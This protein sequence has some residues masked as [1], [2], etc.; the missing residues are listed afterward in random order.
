MTIEEVRREIARIREIAGDDES[1]HSAEDK[2][3][4]DVLGAIAQGVPNPGDLAAE[5][6]QTA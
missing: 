4:S 2:L 3:W 6:L 1:A 5:A